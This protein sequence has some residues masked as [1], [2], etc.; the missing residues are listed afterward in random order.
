MA[1]KYNNQTTRLIASTARYA[2]SSETEEQLMTHAEGVARNLWEKHHDGSGD[3]RAVRKGPNNRWLIAEE[4]GK[5][6]QNLVLYPKP[7]YSQAFAKAISSTRGGGPSDKYP[8]AVGM[9]QYAKIGKV[10]SI[11]FIQAAFRQK[12]GKGNAALSRTLATKYGGWQKHLLDHLFSSAKADGMKV[13]LELGDMPESARE[14]NLDRFLAA[15]GKNG[16]EIT[17]STTNAVVAEHDKNKA[18]DAEK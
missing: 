7:E 2:H 3:L 10:I 15:A 12:D 1:P 11:G 8:G 14:N 18:G 4:A 9:L 17:R 13:A 6:S 16:F 5:F